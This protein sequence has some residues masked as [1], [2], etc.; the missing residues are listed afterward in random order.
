MDI[1]GQEPSRRQIIGTFAMILAW[2]GVLR[3]FQLSGEATSN[4]RSLVQRANIGTERMGSHVPCKPFLD[5]RSNC[6][7][8][9]SIDSR[10]KI[11][12]TTCIVVERQM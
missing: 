10:L 5:S 3:P 8:S 7:K 2:R 4:Q 12:V 9:I 1:V 6:V 11:Q